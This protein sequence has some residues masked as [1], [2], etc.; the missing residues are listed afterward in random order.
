MWPYGA[1][2]IH[3]VPLGAWKLFDEETSPPTRGNE[4]QELRLPAFSQ[5]PEGFPSGF[6]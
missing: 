2:Y 3:W 5:E 4:V 1:Y 6:P